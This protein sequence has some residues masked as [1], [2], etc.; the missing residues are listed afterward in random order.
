MS[1]KTSLINFHRYIF[2]RPTLYKVNLHIYKLA[3]RS[4][5]VL[6]S[7][8]GNATG[9]DYF[10]N[11]L[12]KSLTIETVFDVGANDGGYAMTLRNNFPKAS[13]YAFEPHPKTFLRL[14]LVAS[15]NA[16]FAYQLGIG[17]STTTSKLW[18]FADDARLKSTQ[19]TST[20]ASVYK[21]VIEDH[22]KQKA[23]SFN[24][25]LISLDEFTKKEN[26]Q[27][28]D[29]LKIDTEGN[30]YKALLG[31]KQLI[32][33]GRISVIQFEFNE[34]NV[35]SRIFFKNFIDLLPQYEFFRLLPKGMI[36]LGAYRPLEHEIFAFQNIVAILKDKVK[37]F[38]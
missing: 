35:Y 31:A 1:I 10:L 17:E 3:L 33:N 37:E 13:I 30:E 38:N 25:N 8:G 6:N 34:M 15:K 12:N 19:P 5:G 28:I 24:I 2:A 27:T 18:D 16:I 32:K 21:N 9:E 36:K 11:R 14:E 26:I 23:Q 29:F 7:E 22:H 20:L 4:L